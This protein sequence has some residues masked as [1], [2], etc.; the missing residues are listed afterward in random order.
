MNEPQISHT[1]SKGCKWL[2]NKKVNHQMGHFHHGQTITQYCSE[3]SETC[4]QSDN[5]WGFKEIASI[6]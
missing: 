2:K 4:R 6:S 5:Q 3:Y 1:L